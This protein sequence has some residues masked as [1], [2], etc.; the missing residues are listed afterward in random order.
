MFSNL[1][2]TSPRPFTHFFLDT[3]RAL[4]GLER[5]PAILLFEH[6]MWALLQFEGFQML[7]IAIIA[8]AI[9]YL[10]KRFEEM[11]KRP[12]YIFLRKSYQALSEIIRRT[13]GRKDWRKSYFL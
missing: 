5:K 3:V 12:I 13:V 1:R 9:A 11:H 10:N 2:S 6:T 8:I 4:E 7:G